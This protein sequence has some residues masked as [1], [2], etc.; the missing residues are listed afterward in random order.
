VATGAAVAYLITNRLAGLYAQSTV[1][2]DMSVGN[3][4]MAPWAGCIGLVGLLALTAAAGCVD[5]GLFSESGVA[6][7]ASTGGS[8]TGETTGAGGAAGGGDLVPPTGDGGATSSG[9][10]GST[11]LGA[12]GQS[13]LGSLVVLGDSISAG[14]GEAPFYYDQLLAELETHYGKTVDYVN[15][16]QAGST[17]LAL[18]GQIAALPDQLVGPVAVVI[19]SGG[20]N[21]LYCALQIL[22]GVD[23]I[24]RDRMADHID[25]ALTTLLEPDRFGSGVSVRVFEANIYDASDG[26][27]NFGANACAMPLNVPNGSAAIFDQW[28]DVISDQVSAHGQ[29]LID[30]HA[31]FSGHGFNSPPSWYATDCVHPNATGH[32]ELTQ[33]FLAQITG[34]P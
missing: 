34:A 9:A 24:A 29:T 31:D 20:N 11:D 5:G 32:G 12:G 33:I 18:E 23:Q 3:E 30:I 7:P 26:Q 27:G 17:T 6:K 22:T 4:Q 2:L 19:T 28:N 1:G 25:L 21:M 13:D 15:H 8:T 14:G 10:G 16:A